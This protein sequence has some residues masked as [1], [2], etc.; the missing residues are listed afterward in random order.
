[1]KRL[2]LVVGMIFVSYGSMYAQGSCSLILSEAEDLYEAGRLYE[3]TKVLKQSD[4]LDAKK[5]GFTKE[6][7]TKA[8]RLL[9]LVYLFMDNEPDAEVAVINLLNVDKEH[10][11][12]ENDPAELKLMMDKY[13]SKP[14]FRVGVLAGPNLTGVREITEYGTFNTDSINK[15][16]NNELSIHFGVTVEYNVIDNLEIVLRGEYSVQK[17]SVNYRIISEGDDN[18]TNAFVVQLE[19]KQNW[20]KIP[21]AI[22]YGYPMGNVMPYV[23]G[24]VSFDFLVGAKMSGSRQGT[25]TITLTEDEADLKE[26]DM[27]QKS[28]ISYFGGIGLRLNLKRTDFIFLEAKYSVGANN[29]VNGQNRFASGNLNYDMAHIDSDFAINNM[30]LSVGYLRS[31]YSPKKYSEKKLKKLNQ[32]KK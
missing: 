16:Y 17:Y 10:P 22:K 24:G 8:Y 25:T 2:V 15:S 4:C 11:L 9:A 20:F 3:V 19:E 30:A 18:N 6:E 7:K 29:V 31:L 28:N 26:L 32:K 27:R 5:G 12:D 1:M 13:R 21:V 14:I 23:I